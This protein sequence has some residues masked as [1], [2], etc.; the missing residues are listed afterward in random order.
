MSDEY[1]TTMLVGNN[2]PN[3]L[4]RQHNESYE[5][6]IHLQV[7]SSLII[8]HYVY[9]DQTKML[10]NLSEIHGSQQKIQN[11]YTFIWSW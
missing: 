5:Q 4:M 1:T 7:D 3:K 6:T 11:P 8:N 9:N 2:G 10:C